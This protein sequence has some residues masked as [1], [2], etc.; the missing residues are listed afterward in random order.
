[1]ISIDWINN[2]WINKHDLKKWVD[3]VLKYDEKELKRFTPILLEHV[4]KI[5]QHLENE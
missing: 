4:K 5:K 1:M 2:I 3:Q